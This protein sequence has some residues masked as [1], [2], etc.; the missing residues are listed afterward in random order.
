MTT[1]CVKCCSW[2]LIFIFLVV[3]GWQTAV[4]ELQKT[5]DD[6][7]IAVCRGIITALWQ[8]GPDAIPTLQLALKHP[9]SQVRWAATHSLKKIDTVEAA[10]VLS[11]YLDRRR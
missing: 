6:E 2:F 5:L 7:S 10:A 9:N 8:I 1:K 11:E 3:S 4:P